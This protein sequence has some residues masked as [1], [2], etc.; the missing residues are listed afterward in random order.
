MEAF[1]INHLRQFYHDLEDNFIEKE[2]CHYLQKTEW[3]ELRIINLCIYALR[4]AT[5]KLRAKVYTT[6]LRQAGLN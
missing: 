3:P 1:K 6:Y 2:G 4:Q 5:I